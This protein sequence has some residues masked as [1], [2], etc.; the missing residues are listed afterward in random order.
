MNTFKAT[1][2]ASLATLTI[3][4]GL[5]AKAHARDI[6]TG[7]ILMCDTQPQAERLADLLR[8]DTKNAGISVSAINAED[9]R[10]N[11]C[12][13]A[14]VVYLR[15]SDVATVRSAG[16]TFQIAPVLVIGILHGN[17]VQSVPQN[18]YFSVLKV[19]ER[20]A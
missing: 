5:I 12:G 10:G 3:G 20:K 16:D 15:G 17:A 19:D 2:A 6:E 14:D 8:G 11:A 4:A 18:V 13:V 1:F 9:S 7:T